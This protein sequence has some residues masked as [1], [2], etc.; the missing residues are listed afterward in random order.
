M[1][2]LIAVILALLA[3][4]P[5]YASPTEPVFVNST[6]TEQ[7]WL[8]FKKK[9]LDKPDGTSLYENGTFPASVLGP[10][11]CQVMGVNRGKIPA[12]QLPQCAEAFVSE[13]GIDPDARLTKEDF[14][15]RA[16]GSRYYVPR[17]LAQA[18][19]AP[20]GAVANGAG[21]MPALAASPAAPAP[22]GAALV[23]MKR[24]LAVI[25]AAAAAAT[26]SNNALSGRIDGVGQQASAAARA[27]SAAQEAAQ[28][29]G[30]KV[31]SAER[32]ANAASGV[33]SEAK[34]QARGAA[35]SA[36]GASADAAKARSDAASAAGLAALSWSKALE[37]E[38]TLK[39]VTLKVNQ[40][41]WRP[42]AAV[43][44]LALLGGF[45]LLLVRGKVKNLE[46]VATDAK[47]TA[48]AVMTEVQGV[49]ASVADNSA[50]IVDLRADVRGVRDDV[51]G[52][53]GFTQ[54]ADGT[55]LFYH[56]LMMLGPNTHPTMACE[57]LVTDEDGVKRP[58]NI[59]ITAVDN[60]QFTVEGIR[61]QG[62]NLLTFKDL[63]K[64]ILRAGRQ[65]RIVGCKPYIPPISGPDT[66]PD[67]AVTGSE[68]PLRLPRSQLRAGRTQLVA[69]P[70][71]DG[72]EVPLFLRTPRGTV[73]TSLGATA[74]VAATAD[75]PP[76]VD[77]A[78]LPADQSVPTEPVSLDTRPGELLPDVR[79]GDPPAV[80]KFD[81]DSLMAQPL[82]AAPAAAADVLP[83]AT[84]TAGS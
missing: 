71:A 40:I 80:P 67:T 53:P 4:V 13:N 60:N 64:K 29:V 79:V 49:K 35:A 51:E 66:Q 57:V 5:A 70:L 19:T 75:L 38:E 55:A 30:R 33:A 32:M 3:L 43:V 81:F 37:V 62:S 9:F 84:G 21:A 27:A 77:A 36:A 39:T 76:K 41:D 10:I 42:F 24:Q 2:R 45:A 58:L 54:L 22:D 7:D 31:D 56:R 69:A 78:A 61:D 16:E 34:A 12:S 6:K 15:T 14:K 11:A 59:N 74:A 48:T 17:L 1:N 50:A 18:P 52:Q 28:R 83:P 82:P 8:G 73:G 26:A 23:E 25:N 20:P 68:P 63:D 65:G 72:D 46:A 47:A 44:V